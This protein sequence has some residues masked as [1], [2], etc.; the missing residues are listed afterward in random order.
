VD[1]LQW[2][3]E[4]IVLMCTLALTKMIFGIVGVADSGNEANYIIYITHLF[5]SFSFISFIYTLVIAGKFALVICLF[6]P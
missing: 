5:F 6:Y 1:E 2:D 3:A 4:F